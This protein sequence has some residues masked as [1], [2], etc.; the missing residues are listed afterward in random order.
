MTV[1]VADFKKAV[2][3]F[4]TGVT[5]IATSDGKS[6]A[7]M[8]ANAIFSLSLNP[9]SIVISLQ[10]DAETTRLIGLTRKGAVSFLSSGQK[11]VSE[12]FSRRNSQE[13]KFR[14]IP[15]TEGRNGQPIMDGCISAIEIDVLNII[16]AADHQLVVANV[17]RVVNSSGLVPLIYYSSGYATVLPDGKIL[18][19]HGGGP[20]HSS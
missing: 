15:W 3:R 13:E 10:S 14:T 4:P 12:M 20:D 6:R 7:G 11:H 8:T 17:T 1:D 19:P 18:L 9:P 16:P 5:V 2:S